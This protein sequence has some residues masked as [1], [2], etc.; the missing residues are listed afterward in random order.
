MAVP[1]QMPVSPMREFFAIFAIVVLTL[2][3]AGLLIDFI[4]RILDKDKH[5]NYYGPM[6]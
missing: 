5:D 2:I 3:L 1:V 6:E 4:F